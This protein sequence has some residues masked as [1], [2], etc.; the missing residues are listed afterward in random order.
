MLPFSLT[1]QD[2]TDLVAFLGTLTAEKQDL[3]LPTLPN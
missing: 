1:E 2:R 3:P